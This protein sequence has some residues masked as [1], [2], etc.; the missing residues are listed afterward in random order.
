M[1]FLEI[2]EEHGLLADIDRW[3]VGRAIAVIGERR[4]RASAPR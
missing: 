4:A 1:A 2:A 3:V